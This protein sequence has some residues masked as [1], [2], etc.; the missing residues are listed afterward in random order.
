MHL[1]WLLAAAI[2]AS[3]SYVEIVNAIATIAAT[4]SK[5]FDSNGNQFFIKGKFELKSGHI[6]NQ[7]TLTLFSQ[8][9]HINPRTTT[10]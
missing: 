9:W 8:A 5:L 1:Q 4:G 7:L 2:L 10:P 3:L 6:P